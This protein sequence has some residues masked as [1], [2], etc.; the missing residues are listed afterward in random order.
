MPRLVG[1]ELKKRRANALQNATQISPK[2]QRRRPSL[3]K[4]RQ[5]LRAERQIDRVA[6]QCYA[7]NQDHP[8]LPETTD[9]NAL[10]DVLCFMYFIKG[11]K[12]TKPSETV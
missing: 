11:D 6:R 7:K 9:F 10:N 8:T 1:Y 5:T 2:T 3:K 4:T 12:T